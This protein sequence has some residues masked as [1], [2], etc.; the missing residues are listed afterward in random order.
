MNF[1]ECRCEIRIGEDKEEKKDD[2]K[3]RE[4]KRELEEKYKE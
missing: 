2:K 4:R 3:E 1:L